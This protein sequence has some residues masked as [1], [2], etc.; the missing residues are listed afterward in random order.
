MNRLKV[1]VMKVL[2]LHPGLKLAS[3]K[4]W[5]RLKGIYYN[6][7][8]ASKYRTDSGLVM[9]ESFSGKQYSCNPRALYQELMTN[10]DYEDYRAVWSFKEPEK[11]KYLEQ[12][13]RT[14]VVRY[15]SREYYKA[16]AEAKYWVSNFRLGNELRPK[17]DQVYIQTWHGTPLK[18]LGF[19]IR[20][21]KGKH[22]SDSELA[23]QYVTDLKRYSY[24]LSPSDF[25][26]EKM[27]SAFRLKEYNKDHIFIEGGYPRNDF[28]LKLTQDKIDALKK[29]LNI[30]DYKKVILYAP[31][32]RETNHKAGEGYGYQLA[33]DFGRWKEML[34]EDTIILFRCHYL[35]SR[36]LDL[37]AYEGFVLDMSQQDD[38]NELYAVSDVLITDYSS[39]FFD[40]ANLNRQ[41]IF[42]MYDYREYKEELR[43]FYFPE[44]ELPGPV[45]QEEEELL[46]LL[47]EDY[48]PEKYRE[49]Y[50]AFNL[51]YNPHQEGDG[52]QTV[53]R[54]VFSR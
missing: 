38:I 41:I 52:S 33:A 11:Y 6:K 23:Y 51:K 16:F 35:I 50:N 29:K 26:R 4:V 48:E 20:N 53:W 24:M 34:G 40:Y 43:G 25:Y 10:P 15:R 17:K 22:S 8:Y 28:L 21:F 9:F 44:T 54:Y 30:S 27:T 5:N 1:S 46:R 42:Y 7:A 37:S 12:D 19:D 36:N 47:Q 49:K 14:K 18:R 45:V 13:G 3:L 2:S 32:W 39:V 31:T